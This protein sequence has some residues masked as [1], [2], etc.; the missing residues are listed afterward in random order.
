MAGKLKNCPR[1][2]ALFMDMG[3]KMC[4]ECIRAE[5]EMEDKAADYVREHPDAHVKEIAKETGVKESIIMRMV[6]QGRFMSSS[7]VKISYPCEH[8][9]K[10]IYNGR[11]CD[12]CNRAL[13]TEVKV[14]QAQKE[15]LKTIRKD[16]PAAAKPA[17]ASAAAPVAKKK[18]AAAT[19]SSRAG[20]YSKDMM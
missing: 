15:R 18:P 5:Q 1:C 10:P 8:C 17:A 11:L 12:A 4:P 14:Q 6:R 2:G 9:G 13:I 20:M 16:K 19:S 3:Q 7:G